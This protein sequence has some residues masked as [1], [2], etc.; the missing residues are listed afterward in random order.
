MRIGITTT[1]SLIVEKSNCASSVGSG[2]V[3]VFSTPSLIG[4]MERAAFDSV[5]SEL[6]EG[7][8]T[9]GTKISVNHLRASKIG[10]RIEAKSILT[11]VEERKLTFSLTATD[12]AG[13]I[14]GEGVHERFIINREKFLSKL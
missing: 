11:V 3:D 7:F 5:Q 14:I 8:T 4:L 6:E 12:S 1:C 2:G 13:N 9:V 10:E